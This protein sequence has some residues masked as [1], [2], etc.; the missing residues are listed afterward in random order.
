[1]K[2]TYKDGSG[3][4]DHALEG[5][6]LNILAIVEHVYPP[7]TRLVRLERRVEGPIVVWKMNLLVWMHNPDEYL[8]QMAETL[9]QY[10]L[11][12]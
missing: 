11:F 5:T 8:T 2:T 3:I 4:E 9:L 7:L 12:V 10:I 1:M 6:V